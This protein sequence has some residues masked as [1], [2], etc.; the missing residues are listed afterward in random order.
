MHSELESVI[1]RIC[2]RSL[3]KDLACC[4]MVMLP[5]SIVVESLKEAVGEFGGWEVSQWPY[6]GPN[7]QEVATLTIKSV[8]ATQAPQI[9]EI[10]DADGR[11]AVRAVSYMVIRSFDALALEKKDVGPYP[12]GLEGRDLGFAALA[13]AILE[14]GLLRRFLH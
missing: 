12:S 1:N 8:C 10:L 6:E 13:T 4:Q 9:L 14:S 2:R 11:N 3:K 5:A 7:L